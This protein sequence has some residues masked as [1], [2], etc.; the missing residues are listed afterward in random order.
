MRRSYSGEGNPNW[1]NAGV[2]AC[3]TCGS[4]YKSY[5]KTRKFCSRQC[6][7]AQRFPNPGGLCRADRKRQ[8]SQRRRARISIQA[9]TRR[10]AVIDTESK[11]GW[12]RVEPPKRQFQLLPRRRVLRPCVVCGKRIRTYISRPKK[13]CSAACLSQRKSLSQRGEKSHLWRGGITKANRLERNSA[14]YGDWRKQVFE[15]DN[16]T[17]QSC[18]ERG[19]KLDADHIKPW[20]LFPES[21]YDLNNGRTLC[22]PCHLKTDTWGANTALLA[23]RAAS[24]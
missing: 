12:L 7:I 20:A 11:R 19:G 1:S 14:R 18:G 3:V 4:E 17:C 8:S 21:R 23:Y 6:Y 16:Y 2:R 13:T 10:L 9:K 24:A 15:R 22:R 5:N